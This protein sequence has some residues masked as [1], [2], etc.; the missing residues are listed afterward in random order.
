VGL[1]PSLRASLYSFVHLC[2]FFPF[3]HPHVPFPSFSLL[4]YYLV[5]ASQTHA[6][7]VSLCSLSFYLYLPYTT[8]LLYINPSIYD[9]LLS[10]SANTIPFVCRQSSHLGPEARVPSAVVVARF[11]MGSVG[12]A[13]RVRAKAFRI[14][15]V[16]R[17]IIKDSGIYSMHN[18]IFHHSI[19]ILAIR[20]YM[21][22][23]YNCSNLHQSFLLTRTDWLANSV[24]TVEPYLPMKLP[25]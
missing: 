15:C 25:Q 4:S 18:F 21:G 20:Y 13:T 17:E 6:T 22:L 24:F 11:G 14:R 5:E 19:L 9:D 2:S 16:V 23:Q 12:W 1:I 3:H 8:R 7:F 10:V